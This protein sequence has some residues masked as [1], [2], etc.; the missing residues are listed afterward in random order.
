MDAT[1]FLLL[2]LALSFYLIGAIG[3][4]KLISS[5]RGSLLVQRIST[6]SRPYTGTSFPIGFL[7]LL[8]WPSQ[9]RSL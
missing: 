2:N 8:H 6:Q 4:T 1:V 3:H 7:R 5:G 9:D